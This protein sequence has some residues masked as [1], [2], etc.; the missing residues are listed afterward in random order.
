M[1]L[2]VRFGV[3]WTADHDKIVNRTRSPTSS[4][5]VFHFLNRELSKTQSTK[6]DKNKKKIN[7]T[8]PIKHIIKE[9]DFKICY[10]S[11][12]KNS[13]TNPP[14]FIHLFFISSLMTLYIHFFS[15]FVSVTGFLHSRLLFTFNYVTSW[16]FF[17]STWYLEGLL[18]KETNQSARIN[19]GA[20][21]IK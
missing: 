9:G 15:K 1:S 10:L 19:C 3:A 11:H 5:I 7:H 4:Y 17:Y 21:K 2:K 13:L 18:S 8:S 14:L 16:N 12:T 20:Q 6:N